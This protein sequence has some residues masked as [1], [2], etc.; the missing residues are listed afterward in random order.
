MTS[1][2]GCG[3]WGGNMVSDNIGL[4]YYMQSTWV[5]RPILK[6]QPEESILF[7]EFF[8]PEVKRS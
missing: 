3:I 1:S 5:A 2:M 6:D 7:G 4:K 8:D